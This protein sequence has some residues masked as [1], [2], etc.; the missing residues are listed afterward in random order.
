MELASHSLTASSGSKNH[1]TTTMNGISALVYTHIIPRITSL[2][3]PFDVSVREVAHCST[4][5]F[6]CSRSSVCICAR[7]CAS[8]SVCSSKAAE[9]VRYLRPIKPGALFIVAGRESAAC[10][11]RQNGRGIPLNWNHVG[12]HIFTSA[13]ELKTMFWRVPRHV[14]F[15]F[16]LLR[17]S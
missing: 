4:V 12:A 16:F 8:E 9:G 17:A 5:F 1:N 3:S 6:Y 13:A 7:M 14:F 2:S 15:F 10:W 11:G